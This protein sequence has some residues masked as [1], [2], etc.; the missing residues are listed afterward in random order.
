MLGPE[1]ERARALYAGGVFRQIYSRGGEIPGAVIVL[2]AADAAEAK[3]IV[4]TLRLA[5]KGMI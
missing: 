5:Q 1:A 2:E 3:S 4:A